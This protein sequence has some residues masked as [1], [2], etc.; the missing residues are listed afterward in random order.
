MICICELEI[1]ICSVCGYILLPGH[2]ENYVTY[3]TLRSLYQPISCRQRPLY[4]CESLILVCIYYPQS[5]K[6]PTNQKRHAFGGAWDSAML[7]PGCN[8]QICPKPRLK[9]LSQCYRVSI[10][11]LD[12]RVVGWTLH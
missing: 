1:V 7:I 3:Y 4:G 8:V 9:C 11:P 2:F 10:G 5:K 12:N 6:K